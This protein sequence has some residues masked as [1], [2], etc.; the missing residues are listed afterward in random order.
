MIQNDGNQ[1]YL[2]VCKLRPQSYEKNVG[3]EQ[4]YLVESSVGLDGDASLKSE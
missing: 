4:F 2:H 1:A 3:T